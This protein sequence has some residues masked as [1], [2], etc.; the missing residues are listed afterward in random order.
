MK[1]VV[2]SASLYAFVIATTNFSSLVVKIKSMNM[3]NCFLHIF[4]SYF[5]IL[6]KMIN[7]FTLHLFCE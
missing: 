7:W 6:T 2:N 5:I 3:S 4:H 1:W